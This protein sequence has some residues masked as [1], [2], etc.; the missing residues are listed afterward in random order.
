MSTSIF[1]ISLHRSY[2]Y[3]SSKKNILYPVIISQSLLL[4]SSKN[5]NNSSC[6][7]SQLSTIVFSTG[8]V[9]SKHAIY[10]L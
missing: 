4:I 9:C 8:A 10:C 6:S 7:V 3:F 5:L 1:N 2:I